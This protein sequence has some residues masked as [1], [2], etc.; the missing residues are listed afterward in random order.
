MGFLTPTGKELATSVWAVLDSA[1]FKGI[2]TTLP[3][4]PRESTSDGG[5]R[6]RGRGD[7]VEV[8]YQLDADQL[9][10]NRIHDGRDDA[11]L[12][13]VAA[14]MIES[15]AGVLLASGFSFTVQPISH[16]LDPN[17]DEHSA[18]L[19]VHS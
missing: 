7:K 15:M 12:H 3:P 16:T 13:R 8:F 10:G 2:D 5:F 18:I 4:L 1:G 19:I 11:L 17:T 6:L 9:D 14:L